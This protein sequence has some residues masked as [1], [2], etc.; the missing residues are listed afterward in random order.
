MSYDE[1]L[2]EASRAIISSVIFEVSMMQM[3]KKS[4]PNEI[5]HMAIQK[6]C[7]SI[8]TYKEAAQL[9]KES[10]GE[11]NTH[12]ILTLAIMLQMAYPVLVAGLEQYEI[13]SLID[14]IE[15]NIS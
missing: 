5:P 10:Q 9:Q 8:Q 11:I 15:E 2:K 7:K 3:I 14:F 1:P 13:R 4:M 12:H 6:T